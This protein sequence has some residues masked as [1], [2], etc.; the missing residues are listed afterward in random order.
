MNSE[1]CEH[2][3]KEASP[4]TSSQQLLVAASPCLI[5]QVRAE[6]EIHVSASLQKLSFYQLLKLSTQAVNCT[7]HH[8]QENKTKHR[9]QISLHQITLHSRTKLHFISQI[10]THQLHINNIFDYN[11]THIEQHHIITCHHVS[12]PLGKDTQDA[13]S[14]VQETANHMLYESRN[15]TWHPC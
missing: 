9:F 3:C 13:E 2:F 4:A 14:Q 6:R 1:Q 7:I 11:T 10:T 8:P 15:V 5:K 12:N